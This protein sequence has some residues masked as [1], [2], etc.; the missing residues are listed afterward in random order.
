[1]AEFNIK[2]I[3]HAGI[4]SERRGE[5]EKA[6]QAIFNDAF[7]KVSDTVFVGWGNQS[8]SDNIRLHCVER[9][10]NSLIV[11]KMPR[12]PTLRK[13]IGGHT[14]SRGKTVA[15]EFYNTLHML[16][17]GREVDRQLPGTQM[18]GLVFHECLH[19]VDPDA[20]EDAIGGLGGYGESPVKAEMNDSLRDHISSKIKTKRAQLTV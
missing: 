9:V 17:N 19:N 2:M 11:K 18:A 14:T 13:R 5:I 8:E 6:L 3:N 4:S 10:E 15:S 12:P 1:M 16:S 7:S 20:S